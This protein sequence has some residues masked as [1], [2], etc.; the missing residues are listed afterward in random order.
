MPR[1]SA[2]PVTNAVEPRVRPTQVSI[3]ALLLGGSL[4]LEVAAAALLMGGVF[5]YI[6]VFKVVVVAFFIYMIWLGHNWARLTFTV[7]FALVL[8]LFAPTLRFIF[9]S[10]GTVSL[11]LVQTLLQGAALYL[12]FTHPGRDWFKRKSGVA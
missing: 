2:V 12:L 8:I 3:A 4:L 11:G 9:T 7:L 6:Q 10:P 1:P 5:F